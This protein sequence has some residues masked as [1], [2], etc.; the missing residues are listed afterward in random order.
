MHG[1][2]LAGIVQHE[3]YAAGHAGGEVAARL[4]QND[5]EPLG[6]V[7][8]AVIAYAFHHGGGAGVAH[9]ESLAGHAVEECLAAGGAVKHYVAHQDVFLGLELRGFGR[10]YNQLAARETL[11]D[12]IVGVAFEHQ[13]H[14][15]G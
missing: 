10:I 4:A 8:A 15:L 12:V 6:H 1:C 14:A 9:R 13:R 11:A 3:G 7:L 2:E 5:N